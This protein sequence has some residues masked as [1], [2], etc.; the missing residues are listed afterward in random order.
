MN[1]SQGKNFSVPI[2]GWFCCY[3]LVGPLPVECIS[4]IL[5]CTLWRSS[6]TSILLLLRFCLPHSPSLPSFKI[7]INIKKVCCYKLKVY[8]SWALHSSVIFKNSKT[9]INIVILLSMKPLCIFLSWRRNPM[10]GSSHL[11]LL[12]LVCRLWLYIPSTLSFQ[13]EMS[14]FLVC[15]RQCLFIS[16]IT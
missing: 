3:W 16:I 6:F 5:S 14:P 4:L 8:V 7:I 9:E 15:L 13:R 1:P 11:F 12:I 2:A 10:A